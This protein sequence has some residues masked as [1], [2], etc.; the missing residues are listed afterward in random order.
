VAAPHAAVVSRPSLHDAL[1]IYVYYMP[2]F[3]LSF[4][5]AE[6]VYNNYRDLLPEEEQ[7]PIKLSPS[8]D[9][10][11]KPGE[12]V[13]GYYTYPLGKTHLRSEEHTS[14]LQSRENLACRHLL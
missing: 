1:P 8:N 11:L 4:T 2:A 9:Y 14:E 6:K 10:L 12:S 7:L 5:G 3:Y 13:T